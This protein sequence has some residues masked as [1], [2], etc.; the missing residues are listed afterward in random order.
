VSTQAT[1][2]A[3]ESVCDQRHSEV[4]LG[5]MQWRAEA[6]K[7]AGFADCSKRHGVKHC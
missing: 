1:L 3:G 4:L 2:Q 7:L 6:E 5:K